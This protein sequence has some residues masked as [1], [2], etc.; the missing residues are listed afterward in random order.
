[1]SVDRD[2]ELAL[3]VQCPARPRGCGAPPGE[4]CRNLATGGPLVCRPA[5]EAR[6]WLAEA[7]AMV[8]AGEL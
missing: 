5:H 4:P 1:M 3:R 7:E 2:R 6:L 8:E